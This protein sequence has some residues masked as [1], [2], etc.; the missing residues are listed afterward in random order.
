MEDTFTKKK[1]KRYVVR[2]KAKLIQL[3]ENMIANKGK[4]DPAAIGM[5]LEDVPAE[6]AVTTAEPAQNLNSTPGGAILNS[7]E[8]EALTRKNIQVQ[9]QKI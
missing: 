4:W 1:N 5:K 3:F 7:L 9:Q 8:F 6:P 2:S